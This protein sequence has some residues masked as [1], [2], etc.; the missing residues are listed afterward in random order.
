M[1]RTAEAENAMHKAE[2]QIAVV[3]SQ[4]EAAQEQAKERAERVVSLESQ[5]RREIEEL[6]SDHRS[7]I[8]AIRAEIPTALTSHA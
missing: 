8:K 7:A 2:Q 4:K 6:R 3:N 1:R 5:Y